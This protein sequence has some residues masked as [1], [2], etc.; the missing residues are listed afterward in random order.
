M[1]GE[2]G[3]CLRARCRSTHVGWAAIFLLAALLA[4]ASASAQT[5]ATDSALL[6]WVDESGTHKIEAKF[7]KLDGANVVLQTELGKELNVPYAKLN[8]SSQLQAKKLD[9]PKAFEPPPLPSSFAP[10]PL[11]EN[12]FPEDA[13]IEQFLDVLLAEIKADRVDALWFA[14]TPDMQAEIEAIVLKGADVVGPKLIKQ[15]R[16]VLPG[17]QTLIHDKR[18]FI[19]SHPRLARQPELGKP[20]AACLAAI[21][22]VL[23]VFKQPAQ[24]SSENFKP[25]K[26]APWLVASKVG[27]V[28]VAIPQIAATANKRLAAPIVSRTGTLD[29]RQA[30]YKVLEKTTDTAKVQ[31]EASGAKHQVSFK[32][33]GRTWLPVELA[34]DGLAGLVAIK[35][36]LDNMDKAATDQLRVNLTTGLTF[37][38]AVLTRLNDARTQQEFSPVIDPWLMRIEQWMRQAMGPTPQPG[39][40]AGQ[41]YGSSAMPSGS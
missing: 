22:P 36:Q 3:N 30:T 10:P 1:L 18:S 14:L 27:T 25:G 15:M 9:D 13:T 4:P 32:K 21:D 11:R 8:L 28:L 33:V 39:M 29:Y 35:S 19:L 37:A 2:F 7:V 38:N 20:I 26:V 23:E 40:P 6:T 34:D 17:F 41:D 5:P 16:A 24:W 12:P 31:F